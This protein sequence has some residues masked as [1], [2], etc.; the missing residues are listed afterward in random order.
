[1]KTIATMIKSKD[2]SETGNM[3]MVLPPEF[4]VD[5]HSKLKTPISET[6][7]KVKKKT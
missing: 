1:M 5:I 7:K 4:R 3:T 6:P 2:I